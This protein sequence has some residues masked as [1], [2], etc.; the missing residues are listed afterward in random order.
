MLATQNDPMKTSLNT[1]TTSRGQTGQLITPINIT[2]HTRSVLDRIYWQLM[3]NPD[4]TQL[5][6]TTTPLRY[7]QTKGLISRPNEKIAC[8]TT[9]MAHPDILTTYEEGLQGIKGGATTNQPREAA[10][11]QQSKRVGPTIQRQRENAPNG[12][13]GPTPPQTAKT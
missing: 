5:N 1:T 4:I 13:A 11:G 3:T 12:K 2:A 10:P 6:A 7:N 8:A 9:L